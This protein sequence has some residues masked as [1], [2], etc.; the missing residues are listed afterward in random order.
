[1]TPPK[2]PC[3]EAERLHALKMLDILDTP[4]EEAF[5][6]VT[7]MAKQVF[8]VRMALVSLI[9]S[10]R[11]WFKSIQGLDAT[12]TPREISF[13]GHAILNDDLF[14]IPDARQDP[15]F[16][17]N[18]LVT[19][20][21]NIRFYAGYPLKLR[22]GINIGTLCLIDSEPKEL[23][24]DQ[25]Q[26]LC[27]LGAMVEHEIHTLQV[28]TI[29]E[30]TNIANRRGLM[31]CG[32]QAIKLCKRSKIDSSVLLF[33][34]NKFKAINDT[35]GHAEGDFVLQTFAQQLVK[36]FRESDIVARWG[37]DEFAVFLTDSNPDIVQFSISRFSD[38]IAQINQELGKP[39][40]IEYSLGISHFKHDS[41][42]TLEERI[43][44]ADCEMYKDKC[45]R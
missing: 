26:L 7:R 32:E 31:S 24:K 23:S 43:E 16:S 8:G 35:Y 36:T 22:P 30:L 40:T 20:E 38:N 19:G 25:R 29:D 15:R 37:G 2:M 44:K 10:D 5:D 1:M 3:N 13:C 39:Y 34:L 6:R 18:P 42:A 17:D 45:P 27:D 11:Q 12:E 28:A 14:I 4:Y 21:P 9:D 33:D 41:A